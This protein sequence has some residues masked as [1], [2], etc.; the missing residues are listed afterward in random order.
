MTFA[1]QINNLDEADFQFD[2][3]ETYHQHNEPEID[4][5]GQIRRA[6]GSE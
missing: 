2:E 1:E 5:L 6:F 3:V 4:M